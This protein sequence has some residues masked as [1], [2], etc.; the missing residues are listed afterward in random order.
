MIIYSVD[1]NG[2]LLVDLIDEVMKIV[3]M[4][5]LDNLVSLF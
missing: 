1:G 2:I 3:C 4:F 5:E